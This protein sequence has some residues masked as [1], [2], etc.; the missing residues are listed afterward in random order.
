MTDSLNQSERAALRVLGLKTLPATPEA[1][2]SAFSKAI[3]R[4]HPDTGGTD[5]DARRV[6]RAHEVLL[7]TLARLRV[8]AVYVRFGSGHPQRAKVRENQ[9]SGDMIKYVVIVKWFRGLSVK[10]G[11]LDW[12]SVEAPQIF[13]VEG[14]RVHCI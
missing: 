2:R 6:L 13:E 8:P 10:V 5:A 7:E 1:L 3:S 14:V 11:A 4:A 12:L 9:G